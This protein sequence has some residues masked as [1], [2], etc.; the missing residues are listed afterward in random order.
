MLIKCP[1][2]Q[3]QA[4]DKA[5][6]CP[7]C[8][9]PLV[10]S[11]KSILKSKTTKKKH[12]RLPNGFGQI[13]ELKGRNLRNP[14]RV[15]ITVGKDANGK[16]IQRALKPTAYF[17]TYNEAYEALVE[18]H[19]NPYDLDDDINVL[20]LYERWSESYFKTLKADSSIRTITAAWLYCGSLYRM[21]AKDVRAHHL[22]SC[23]EEG[24]ATINGEVRKPTAGVKSRMKS[25]FNLLFDYA[26]EYEITDRNYA[27]TFSLSDEI[28]SEKEA[29]HKSH[30]PFTDGEIKTLWE[31]VDDVPITDLILIQCYSGWRPQELITLRLENINLD[32]WTFTGG[33]KTDAGTNRTVPIHER[34]RPLIKKNYQEAVELGSEYLFNC[35]DAHT[36]RSKLEYTY[37]K[38]SYRFTK[39]LSAIGINEQHRPHDPRCHFIT[40]AKKYQVDEYAIKYMVGHAILDITEKV[41]TK[42][43]IDWLKEEISKIK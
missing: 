35:T 4:S 5:I 38:Y 14:Y 20:E 9:F 40:M 10:P 26:V 19:K 31:H 8:G 2:C 7:H 22:K 29:L 39:T 23:I 24:T 18:Y 33:M 43:S 27:R 17:R 11:S 15:L 13:S 30:I 42:R 28:I 34:I 37:E 12:M 41:Y 16:P 3:L 1:E 32:D 25:L 6:Q 21:R 36:H